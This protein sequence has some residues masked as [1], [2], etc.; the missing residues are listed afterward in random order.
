MSALSFSPV[1]EAEQERVYATLV[2]AFAADPV[3]RWLYPEP[4]QYL[5][6]FP[7][8]LAAFGGRA[9]AGQTVWSLGESAVALWL[10]PAP[11]QTVT[12]SPPRSPRPSHQTSMMTC[13]PSL[14]RWTQ[15]IRATRTGTCRGSRSTS[16]CRAQGSAASCWSFACRSWM[17]LTSPP[18]SKPPTRAASPSTS[19]TVSRSPAKRALEHA[20]RSRSCCE[21]RGSWPEPATQSYTLR[22]CPRLPSTG[23]P[24]A[25]VGKNQADDDNRA[26]EAC[27]E[28]RLCTHRKAE[29]RFLVRNRPLCLVA[30]A[31][32]EPAT[33]GL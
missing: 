19:V 20:R 18:T 31:G 2:L 16:P 33:S 27:S 7:R 22:V 12:P 21:L 13:S 11:K 9:F 28:Q 29:G 17:T 26:D 15:P 23:F 8:F 5:L 14:A 6:Y 25:G 30:G 10:P 1:G 32:F 4:R 3:E 24:R